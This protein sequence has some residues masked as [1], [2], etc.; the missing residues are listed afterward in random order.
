MLI[1]NPIEEAFYD[2]LNSMASK[3]PFDDTLCKKHPF[4]Y[5]SH[6][7]IYTACDT[8]NSLLFEMKNDI[9]RET[10]FKINKM[11]WSLLEYSA[12]IR[13]H[14]KMYNSFSEFLDR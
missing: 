6:P 9:S 11:I 12:R 14:D 4:Q 3:I 7:Q 2:T 1:N 8:L 13:N 10:Y 5:M